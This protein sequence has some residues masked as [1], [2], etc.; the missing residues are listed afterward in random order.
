MGT[1]FWERLTAEQK[2]SFP[3][4]L[5]PKGEQPGKVV[6][7]GG[8]E[9]PALVWEPDK[10]SPAFGAGHHRPRLTGQRR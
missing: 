3:E 1:E 6:N 5:G 2:E 4:L 8:G 7:F 9:D 10:K